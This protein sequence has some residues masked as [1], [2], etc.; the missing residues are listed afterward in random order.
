M[1]VIRSESEQGYWSND[2]GW[3]LHPESATEFSSEE[4]A[5]H[6]P[7]SCGNDA[8]W[9]NKSEAKPFEDEWG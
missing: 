3:M 5:G 2:D 6:L 9:V 8:E 4:R 1:Y 7:M